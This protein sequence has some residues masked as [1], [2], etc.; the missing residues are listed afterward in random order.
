VV[1]TGL[2]WSIL[3][4]TVYTSITIT[5]SRSFCQIVVLSMFVAPGPKRVDIKSLNTS[6]ILHW[7]SLAMLRDKQMHTFGGCQSSS[8]KTCEAAK[9]KQ[10]EHQKN[11]TTSPLF[12][13]AGR[14]IPKIPHGQMACGA[15][16]WKWK[17]IKS[18]NVYCLCRRAVFASYCHR[19]SPSYLAAV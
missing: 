6:L 2:Q 18:T 9:T 8:S 17:D 11:S 12:Q 3:V 4:Y 5:V 15:T 10:T 14:Q 13:H 16:R 19:L 7:Q 1:S